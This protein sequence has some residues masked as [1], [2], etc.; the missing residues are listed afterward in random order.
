MKDGADYSTEATITVLLDE[1]ADYVA[2]FE[3]DPDWQNP[4]MNFVG[5]YQCE[6]AHALVECFGTREA[7]ITI[8]WGSSAWELARWDIVGELDTDTLTVTYSDASKRIIVYG[9]DGEVKSEETEYSDGTGSI[10]FRDDGT[11]IW[12]EDQSAS[13]TD[14]VFDWVPVAASGEF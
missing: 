1:S 14:L 13:G 7:W 2:V 8:E 12:H 3:E 11:F 9:D 4:V 10:L 6:R 5:E